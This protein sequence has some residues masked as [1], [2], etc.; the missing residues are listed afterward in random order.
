MKNPTEADGKKLSRVVGFMKGTFKNT[1]KISTETFDQ[2]QAYI[3]AAHEDG[4]GHSGGSHYGLRDC[5]R[6]YHQKAKKCCS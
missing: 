4:Y 2:V 6:V 1:R 3:D 5:G